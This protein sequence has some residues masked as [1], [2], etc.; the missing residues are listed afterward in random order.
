MLRL[1]LALQCGGT[2]VA[3]GKALMRRRIAAPAPST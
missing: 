3:D 2:G 1:D